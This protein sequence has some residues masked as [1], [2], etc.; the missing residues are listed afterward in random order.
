M[1]GT[2]V[3]TLQATPLYHPLR[4]IK[5]KR[6]EEREYERWQ[7]RGRAGKV[8]H[9]AKQENIRALQQRFNLEVLV[10]TGTLYGDMLA[11]MRP[12]FSKLYSIELSDRLHAMAERRFRSDEA[13]EIIHG[14]SGEMIPRLLPRLDQAALFW[15]DGHYSGGVTA[16]ADIDTPIVQEVLAIVA[17]ERYE[18][19]LVVDDARN[20][21]TDPH[22]PTVEELQRAVNDHYPAIRVLH[23]TTYDCLTLFTDK[24]HALQQTSNG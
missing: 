8:P 12:F 6:F 9:R 1:Y 15:L 13:I 20:F 23:D 10:E 17:D 19:V 18:H 22:Y 4:S 21:G 11:A 24:A 14:D 2:L 7:Q 3:R 16:R 5:L